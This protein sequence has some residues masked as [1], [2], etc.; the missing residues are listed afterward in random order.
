MKSKSSVMLPAALALFSA[1]FFLTYFAARGMGGGSSG[2][3]GPTTPA[4]KPPAANPSTGDAAASP[5]PHAQ[6]GDAADDVRSYDTLGRIVT[7]PSK[8][9]KRPLEIHHEVIPHF[10]GRDGTEVGMKEMIMPFHDLAPGVSLEGLKAGD[11]IRFTFEV[12][13][14]KS[15][16]TL[17]TRLTPAE[18]GVTLHLSEI[19]ESK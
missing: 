9:G 17:V 13:W 19:I 3:S 15:P 7:L 8:D 4:A 14:N 10:V 11:A 12:R 2:P 5:T 6:G 18:P 16:R 1:V